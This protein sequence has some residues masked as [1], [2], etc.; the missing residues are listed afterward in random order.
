M[1]V[2]RQSDGA[3]ETGG[4]ED[5]STI[6]KHRCR[7]CLKV[8]GSDSALQIHM[9]SHT[10][11]SRLNSFTRAVA[12]Y[13]DEHVCVS[14]CR[15]AISEITR[16]IFTDFSVHVAYGCGSVLLRQGDEIPRARGSFGGFSSPLR[17]HCNAF[18]ANGIG[19]EGGGRAKCD[20]RLSCRTI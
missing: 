8:L 16:A 15:S 4:V 3:G 2:M 1:T 12:K 13:C 17:M 6:F 10:G 9:R 7:L 19:R 18:A 11:R 14:V 20:L 5:S